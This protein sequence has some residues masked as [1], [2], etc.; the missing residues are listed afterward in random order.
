MEFDQIRKSG[1]S[2]KAS[3]QLWHLKP[4]PIIQ[5]PQDT[6]PAERSSSSSGQTPHSPIGSH[7]LRR[8]WT[9]STTLPAS[10]IASPV[11][12]SR[13]AGIALTSPEPPVL[14]IFTKCGDKYT[15]LHLQ[16]DRSIKLEQQQCQ[17]C[18]KE[19]TQ[20]SR[21]LI[22][23]TSKKFSSK[24]TVRRLCAQ[25]KNEQGL[26]SWNL[27]CFRYPEHPGFK[28]LELLSAKYL[29]LHFDT[30]DK[31]DEFCREVEALENLRNIDLN[32]YERALDGRKYLSNHPRLH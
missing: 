29:S 23:S 17:R 25:Q 28:S 26:D 24:F 7:K 19:K 15:F 31:M 27:G 1:I 13:G 14:I 20:C 5:P 32:D 8:F 12:G 9:S 30:P 2:G 22:R 21:I 4:L 11:N 6:E 3:L 10:S 18:R 16:L